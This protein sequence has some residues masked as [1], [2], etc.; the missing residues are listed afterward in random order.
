MKTALPLFALFLLAFT[1]SAQNNQTDSEHMTFKGVPID[2]TLKEYV[3][4][5]N[6]NGFELIS[7]EDGFAILQGDFAGFKRCTILVS[8]LKGKDLMSD[9]TVV[10]P[11]QDTWSTLAS[12]YFFLQELLTEKYGEP[13]EVIEEFDADYNTEDA[14]WRM[15]YVQTDK[16]KYRTRYFT[17][18]GRIE[19]SIDH[20][21]YGSTFVSLTYSDKINSK[22]LRAK[23]KGDL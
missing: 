22:I 20:G 15:I 1:C 9:V 8:T 13:I 12:N 10:F 14:Q 17:D 16:C 23:A 18:K 3:L 19:L 11:D 7:M 4:K 21:D 2:G 6:A 5:M